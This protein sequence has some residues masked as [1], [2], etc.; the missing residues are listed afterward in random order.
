MEALLDVVDDDVVTCDIHELLF[1]VH[2]QAI[3]ELAVH[4]KD[5][6]GRYR[7]CLHAHISHY[8]V[9][10]LFFNFKLI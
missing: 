3:V 5:K 10:G 8:H 9:A 4:S 2:L 1:L 6:L 7:N